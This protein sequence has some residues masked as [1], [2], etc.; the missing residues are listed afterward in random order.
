MKW[1]VAAILMV[2]GLM[3]HAAPSLA[4]YTIPAAAV[5]QS[6]GTGTE[7]GYELLYA[8]GQ[9]SPVTASAGGTYSLAT[10][11]VPAMADVDPPL[12]AHEPVLLVSERTDLP[13]DL[14]VKDPRAGVDSVTLF[15]RR[16]GRANFTKEPMSKGTGDTYSALIPAATVTE[17][18][19]AYY[20]EATDKIGNTSRFPSGAPD[21]L[22]SL[23]VWFTDLI[24]D[25]ELP[26]EAYR[27][28][29]LP[30]ST[31]GDPDSVLV[32]DLGAYDRTAWRLGRWNAPDTGCADVCYDEYPAIESFH[33]GKAFW[34]I[35]R[36][37]E[38]FDFSGMSVGITRPAAV[39][40]EKGWNQ[41][42][43]PFAFVT[44]WQ[45]AR[46]ALGTETYS[47]GEEHVVGSD[48]LFVEDN[49]IAYDGTYQGLQTE[50]EPWA[51]YWIYNGSTRAVDLLLSP[52][53]TTPTLSAS[54]CPGGEADLLLA[55]RV[56][57]S[58]LSSSEGLAGMSR[59]AEDNWDRLDLRHPPPI[60]DYL[61]TGFRKPAWGR[62]SGFYMCD[63]RGH[64][65][66]GTEW[67]FQ[68]QTSKSAGADLDIDRIVPPP[69]GWTV[70]IYDVNEG[71]RLNPEDLPYHF[72]CEERRDFVLVAGTDEYIKAREAQSSL[73]LRPRIVSVRPNPFL[74]TAEI[75]FFLPVR[76][77]TKLQVFSVEGRLVATL[78]DSQLEPGLHTATWHGT[79]EGGMG[80]APGLYFLRLEVP[81]TIETGKILKVR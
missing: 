71:L 7:G 53:S 73:A 28:I 14:T 80:V 12:L 47:V 62:H 52:E 39:N 56:T 44:D 57:S 1:K 41:I 36:D 76:L 42:G 75:A 26:S 23:R 5:T 63:M 48:T 69:D 22:V 65:E 33:Q 17:K 20:I 78:A 4:T 25:F 38:T 40:L 55:L 54:P 74:R 18:G 46:I 10:G 64:S 30:G 13:V 35:T 81:G 61:R 16:G 15:Y 60:G 31:N 19:L 21:S 58:Q 77:K 43:T 29:S 51:G 72:T 79:S 59:L 34:L 37:T 8:V 11:L 2:S 66:E 70:V 27:M 68:V 50:L 49:L 24:S 9:A 32:D 45:S 3:L 67:S 6:G